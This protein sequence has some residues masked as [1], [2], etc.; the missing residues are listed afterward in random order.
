MNEFHVIC[1]YVSLFW[2]LL[3]AITSN[4][5]IRVCH[6]NVKPFFPLWIHIDKV[7][8]QKTIC[9]FLLRNYVIK[10]SSILVDQKK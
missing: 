10:L 7:F 6:A 1:L 5:F 9:L 8:A 3:H 4:N 2:T